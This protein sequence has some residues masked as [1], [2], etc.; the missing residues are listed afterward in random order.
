MVGEKK[1]L[2]FWDRQPIWREKTAREE[3]LDVVNQVEK[4]R[5]EKE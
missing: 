4:E 3:L 2:G 5:K 1:I